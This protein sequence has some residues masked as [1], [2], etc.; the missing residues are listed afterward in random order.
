MQN[1]E[2]CPIQLMKDVVT[3]AIECTSDYTKQHGIVA[4]VDSF[5]RTLDMD[6]Y[7]I[8]RKEPTD[9]KD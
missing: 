8:V 1:E 6:G 2:Y 9:A 5:I 3:D 7:M 4:N